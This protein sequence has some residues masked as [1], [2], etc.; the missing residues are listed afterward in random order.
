MYLLPVTPDYVGSII[1]KERP[2]GIMLAYGG[3]TALNCGVKLEDTGMLERYGIRVLG[4]PI[5]GIRSTED[6]QL[7]KDSMKEAGVPVLRSRTVTDFAGAKSA[8]EE[9][10]Y[11]VIVR[12]AYTLGGRGGGVAYN[13]IELHEIVE[14][15]LK[16]SLVGQVLVEE[17]VG[18]W[19][20]IEYEVMQD[21]E[22]NSVIVCNMENV[23]SMKVHTGD[24]I[25]VAPSQTISNSEYHM[26][27]SA[28]LRATGHVGIVGECNI[29]YALAPDSDRYVAI[30]INPRL[31]RSSALASKATGYPLAYMSAKIGLGYGLSE[32][33]NRI[34]KST[35]ACFEPSLDYIVCKHPRWDFAKFEM[36]NRRL[37]PTMKSVGEVMA[38]GRTFEE[39]L[40]KAIRMLGIGNDGLVLNR[41]DAPGTGG[42]G[43]AG[44]VGVGVGR[45]N[46]T[47][48]GAGLDAEAIEERLTHHDDRI[49]YNV[50]AAIR[51]GIS[52]ERIYKLSAI[53][54]WFIEKI[55][56]IVRTA[57]ALSEGGGGVSA[58]TMR[59]AKRA[60]F[61]DAQIARARGVSPDDVRDLRKRMG[62]IPSVKQIDT[63]AAEWPAVTNYLYM[64][65]G[66]GSDDVLLDDSDRGV[67]VVGAGP[68][69]IGSSVEFD[70]GTV[71][72]VWG[73]Q[74]SGE[75]NVIVVNCN[76][77]TVST[78]YDICT[79]LYFEEP[80]LERLLDISD[81][82]SP[83]GVIT[84]VGGQTANNLT[85]DAAKRGVL[86]LGTD[87]D[88]VD[89]AEDRSKFS[90][91]L[92]KLRI[93]QPPWQTFTSISDARAFA[94][95]VGYPVIVRPSY[96]LSGAAMKVVWSQ[97]ELH[98]Y[99]R[100]AADVSPNHPVVISKFMLD[101]LEV[102]VDG[103]ADGR[104]VAIGAIVEHIDSAGVH[105]GDAMMCIP[106]WRLS[107]ST[108]DTITE[109]TRKIAL[110]FQ[111]RGPF[112]LQFLVSRGQVYVI[113]LNIR[114]SRS[115]PFVSKL[116]GVNLVSLASRAILGGGPLPQIPEER[117]RR[118]ATYGIKVPQF[119]FMQLDGADIA[120]GVEMQST[121]EAACFGNSFYDALSKGL[122]SVGYNLPESGAALVT[123]GGVHNKERLIPAIA[124]LKDMG[125]RIMATEHTA[126]FISETIGP[127][128]TV[129]KISEPGR[130]PNIT[131]LLY[132]RKLDFILNIP[133]TS[134]LEKY[135]GMLDDEYQIRRK[136]LE[137]GVPVLTT[138]ELAD[139]F[140]RTLEWL[141]LNRTT[142]DPLQPYTDYQ[143]DGS[144]DPNLD[145]Y[146]GG[147]NSGGDDGNPR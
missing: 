36:A 130:K 34:T 79:R 91:E 50:A 89:R 20:Q 70:W 57:G 42:S 45:A 82:E 1:E 104:S 32:L 118:T 125:F 124:K 93:R 86:I 38:I 26:L 103:V 147:D 66:G 55:R 140:V 85:L 128:E 129:Y 77:E 90:A 17:Y 96:V 107:N 127:V 11:P 10:T 110:T 53:D 76:P 117:W 47:A 58:G 39:S 144:R 113:E 71:N 112:N 18:D 88:N 146:D 5:S 137:L 133:S 60:G 52:T 3:Q 73:L 138:I 101:S 131:D 37:G 9:L 119:S 75:R 116:V 100:E 78:D 92:D 102:D 33:V 87:A 41:G 62:I 81:F 72:M 65:Y 16:A 74:E 59:D 46:G 139:S 51:M 114:A 95:E 109:Y 35:T 29:Q 21:H 134:T 54:P 25:V 30:E 135:V 27:R 123:V 120:L 49:L 145:R 105:S 31:S 106:P 56:H 97:D 126:E 67:V 15:G 143:M 83:K 12:V 8:A 64:T 111:V 122:I 22:G 142:R 99:V 94:G 4:T 115:M 6:R 132:E 23:L 68:Y 44:G 61:S 98:R 69:R 43:R 84:C 7:F 141:R 121:G 63:L 14:R 24:N 80:T 108:V 13:E 48:A 40:Q 19:K 2:D 28:A 136:A